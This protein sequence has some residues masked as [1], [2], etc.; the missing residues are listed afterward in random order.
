MLIFFLAYKFAGPGGIAS[1]II[2]TIAFIVAIIIAIAVGLIVFRRVSPMTWISAALIIGFGG[3]TIYLRDPKFIQLKPTI[4]YLLFA[5]SLLIGLALRKAV[6]RWLFGPIFPGLSEVGWLKLTR[7]WALFFLLLAGVNEFMRATLSFD[8][9]LTVK[10]WGVTLATLIFA[11][12]NV[13][14]LM[15][16]GL[17]PDADVDSVARTPVE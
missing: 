15:R 10:V 1:M 17:D 11:G 7:N 16:H 12:A 14:M 3:L 6:L 9:W 2:A 5:G 8:T 13:P 4:I